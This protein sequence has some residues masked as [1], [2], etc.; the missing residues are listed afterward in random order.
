MK[1]SR[2]T[3]LIFFLLS[4]NRVMPQNYLSRALADSMSGLVLPLVSTIVMD[5]YDGT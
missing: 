1:M 2:S 4:F 5:V 3:F